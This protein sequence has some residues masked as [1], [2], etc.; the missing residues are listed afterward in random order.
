MTLSLVDSVST[1]VMTTQR[2]SAVLR[3][4]LQPQRISTSNIPSRNTGFTPISEGQ[5]VQAQQ[6]STPTRWSI[7][8]D[9]GN[10]LIEAL[11]NDLD[12]LLPQNPALYD[13]LSQA[14]LRLFND[15]GDCFGDDTAYDYEDQESATTDASRLLLAGFGTAA[16]RA[17]QTAATA[18]TA[19]LKFR[20]KLAA[21]A[22][23]SFKIDNGL[24][25]NSTTTHIMGMED[26]RASL[27]PWASVELVRRGLSC[28]V[29]D[30]EKEAP[31]DQPN[32]WVVA[33]KVCSPRLPMIIVFTCSRRAHCMPRRTIW[34]GWFLAVLPSI[35][36][37]IALVTTFSGARFTID[38]TKGMRLY[39]KPIL[40]PYSATCLHRRNLR[41][42]S[43]YSSWQSF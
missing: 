23:S 42:V 14:K 28:G 27:L 38:V 7:A 11:E 31:K 8:P 35:V 37:A 34:T 1:V 16:F 20:P 2:P 29:V 22:A 15:W 26:K 43:P 12:M 30:V 4:R 17:I 10:K 32:W 19:Q 24:C 13:A 33:N 5:A 9:L 41:P 39:L 6:L 36:S 25:L 40:P 3:C 21:P 18:S